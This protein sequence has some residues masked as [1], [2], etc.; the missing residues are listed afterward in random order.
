MNENENRQSIQPKYIRI[1]L[2]VLLIAI[3]AALIMTAA[4]II[5]EL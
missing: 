2:A 3:L 1:S 5:V 4:A